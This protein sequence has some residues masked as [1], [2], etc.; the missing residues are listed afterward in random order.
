MAFPDAMA[1]IQKHIRA[2]DALAAMGAKIGAAAGHLAPSD[3]L[4][5]KLDAVVEE[6]E[7]DLLKGL[8]DEELDALYGFVR[9]AMRQ[10]LHLLELPDD[11]SSGWSFDDPS[12]LETQGRS[13][14]LV[15]RL[16]SE[17]AA[18]EPEFGA[19]LSNAARFL[20]VGSGVGWISLSMAQQ[21]PS[22]TATGIDIL[23]PALDLASANLE[24]T[25]LSDRVSFRNENVTDL[26][27][28]AAYDVVFVPVIFLPES[29]I[30]ATF[31]NLHRAL[32]PGGWLFAASYRVPEDRKLAVLNEL[33]TT[34]SGGRAWS[35]K[36]L[37]AMAE[38]AGLISV[39]DVALGSPLH[40][41]AS[42]REI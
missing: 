14:R 33:R 42:R 10:M 17:Y 20:D 15:T 40:L 24:Q 39:G 22:L 8:T 7:P 12:I 3:N 21:W 25:G 26:S 27:E 30:D 6:F 28:T 38:N 37:A 13:S 4:T 16:L 32:K 19:T 41:W 5:S 18:R 29:I 34:V 9:A 11:G 35:D 36:E 1:A 2:A 23:G 31:R